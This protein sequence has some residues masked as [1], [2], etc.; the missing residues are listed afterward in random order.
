MT[1]SEHVLAQPALAR[2]NLR[3]HVLR[4]KEAIFDIECQALPAHRHVCGL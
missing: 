1:S 4:T 3:Y 2:D